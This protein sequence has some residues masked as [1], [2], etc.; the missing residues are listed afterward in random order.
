MFP[1]NVL[2][3]ARLSTH[4]L[5]AFEKAVRLLI[6]EYADIEGLTTRELD[7]GGESVTDVFV[8]FLDQYDAAMV[9]QRIDGEMVE[10]RKLQVR[11]A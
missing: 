2:A 5:L 3:I 7:A 1:S 8:E 10:G 9:K 6:D 4:R 11:I